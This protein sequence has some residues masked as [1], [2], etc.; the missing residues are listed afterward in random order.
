M[1]LLENT[2]DKI[3]RLDLNFDLKYEI[4]TILFDHVAEELENRR[5]LINLAPSFDAKEFV[6]K[7][8][9]SSSFN[10]SLSNHTE[11]KTINHKK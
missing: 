5:M 1:T 2:I 9:D 6:N 10:P 8:C 7:V 3:D 11:T 4:K